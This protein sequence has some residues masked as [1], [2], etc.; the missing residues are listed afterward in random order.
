MPIE[1][2]DLLS[3]PELPQATIS[4][5]H[6]PRAAANPALPKK[7][8]VYEGPKRGNDD[9][10]ILSSD[11]DAETSHELSK[12]ALYAPS[13][14]EPRTTS[15]GNVSK[16][17][18]ALRTTNSG[19][20]VC[21]NSD[22]FD[23][24]VNLDESF[25]SDLPPAKKQRLSSSPEILAPK[26]KPQRTS[27]FQRSVSNAESSSYKP[28]SYKSNFGAI[29]RSKTMSAVLESDP[30]MFTSSPDPFEYATKWRRERERKRM[31]KTEDGD[32]DDVFGFHLPA[33]EK[34]GKKGEGYD[35]SD[36]SSDIELPGL[37]EIARKVNPKGSFG[38]SSQSIVDSYYAEREKEKKVKEAAQK[39]SEKQAK[40]ASKE[41]EKERKRL[42]REEKAAEKERL[43][44]LARVN[45][46][47]TNKQ[48]SSHEMMVDL[49]S[50]LSD[51]ALGEQVV[52][53]LDKA[54]IKHSSCESTLPVVRWRR[55][56]SSE[57]NE[58]TG[59][60]E[61]VPT[62]IE[63]ENHIL[64]IISA[65]EFVELA[66]S[67]EGKDIDSHI[68]SLRARFPSSKIIYLIEGLMAWMRKNKSIQNRKY[69]ETVR[70]QGQ[71]EPTAS[72]RSKK[73]KQEEYI[74][75][76]LVED[77]LLRLQVMHGALIHH[78]AVMVESAE[79]IL[80]FTQ[81]ISTVP[82]R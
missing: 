37:D 39:N 70:N 27:G 25:A 9:W 63:R 14:A 30:I 55:E 62:R 3:S 71:D 46:V 74:D 15:F 66:I 11:S 60:W 31:E 57:Y 21:F 47:R 80:V 40:K 8:L 24:T 82:Y 41:A 53:L 42:E 73:K 29:Q 36:A 48:R 16:P 4:E 19:N 34:T 76:D 61:P 7:A 32:E 78:T 35:I 6:V 56:V 81:H 45:V 77:A 18:Q 49:P 12:A 64:F 10:F 20:R 75:E 28:G 1:V 2:I 69:T 68:L 26:A 38:R 33:T 22:D 54:E 65:K 50:T 72:H 13:T 17:K 52:K 58:E 51:S 67:E 44:E 43:A 59:Q 79:W 23:S 5:E